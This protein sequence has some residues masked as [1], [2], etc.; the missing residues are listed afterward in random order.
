MGKRKKSWRARFREQVEPKQLVTL[1][2][3]LCT[4]LG[5]RHE[6]GVRV[7]KADERVTATAGLAMTANERADVLDVRLRA[8]ERHVR[9]I[10]RGKPV[11]DTLPVYGPSPAPEGYYRR[12]F[13]SRLYHAFKGG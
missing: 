4:V 10:E 8:L 7:G 6:A 12:G 13:M 1:A 2:V 11:R 9:A 3:A 5:V